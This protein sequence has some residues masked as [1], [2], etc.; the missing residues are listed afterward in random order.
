MHKL[1]TILVMLL[2]FTTSCKKNSII[3]CF[4]STG[5][6]TM[7]ERPL[8][9]FH[10]IILK[11]NINLVLVHSDTMMLKLE[12]GSNLMNKIITEIK[13]STLT[14]ENNNSCNWVRD[15]SKPVNVYLDMTLLDT[16]KYMSIG[17]VTCSDTVR[18]Q[19]I[20]IDVHEG[21]G[22]ISLLLNQN[23]CVV[24]L[25]YGT[26]D[27]VLYG[28]SNSCYFYQ[29]S[30]GRINAIDLEA[31]S[32]YSRNWGSNDLYLY[33]KKFLSIE[34]KN[35]GNVYYRGNPQINS[36]ITGSGKLIPYN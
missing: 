33:A 13:D 34:I 19:F 8:T 28:K 31:G 16:L 14:L 29:N 35:I 9:G 4:N 17:N 18:N 10:T 12:A 7:V 15:F 32:V 25:H 3:D 11:D 21:S 27:I 23:I 5:P 36:T 30:F 22:T 1:I 24:N 2:F 20:Q 26:A 6:I